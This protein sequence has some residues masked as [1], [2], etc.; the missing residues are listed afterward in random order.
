MICVDWE[1]ATYGDP[2]HD[3]ATHLVRMEYPGHQWPAV[4]EAWREAMGR[5]RPKAVHGLDRDLKHYLAFE[6]AQSVYPDVMRAASSLGDSFDQQRLDAATH[7]VHRALLEAE[8]PLR[9]MSVPDESEIERTLFRWNESHGGLHN[10]DRSVSEIV[11]ERDHRVPRIRSSPLR[12]SARHCSRRGR[13]PR[14]ACSRERLISTRP[15]GCQ[16]CRFPSWSA[17]RSARRTPASAGSSMSTPSSRP[18]SGQ[19]FPRGSR[20][21]VRGCVPRGCVPHACWPWAPVD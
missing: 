7:A 4:I 8:E 16:K 21:R 14:T 6:R 13:R 17:E 10:R 12:L 20:V 1:L 3:L 9:L 19:T 11:W 15:C 18:S 2:L 5:R